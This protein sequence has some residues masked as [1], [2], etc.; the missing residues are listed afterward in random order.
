MIAKLM[1]DGNVFKTLEV[2]DLKPEIY[3]ALPGNL[4]A[5]SLVESEAMMNIDSPPELRKMVFQYYKRI[6]D[7]TAEYNLMRIE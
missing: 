3:L 5:D 2:Q 4:S 1:V 6:D 7:R